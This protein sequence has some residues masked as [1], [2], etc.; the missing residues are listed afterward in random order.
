[1][2]PAGMGPVDECEELRDWAGLGLIDERAWLGW[3]GLANRAQPN[4]RLGFRHGPH[5]TLVKC[6]ELDCMLISAWIDVLFH[7]LGGVLVNP[8]P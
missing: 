4:H 6:I 3:P 8:S 1:M 7:D 2:S 5:E